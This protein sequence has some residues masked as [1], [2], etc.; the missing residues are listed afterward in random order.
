MDHDH[1]GV[2]AVVDPDLAG[3]ERRRGRVAKLAHPLGVSGPAGPGVTAR[4]AAGP[5]APSRGP[6]LG[7]RAA[8]LGAGTL[9]TGSGGVDAAPRSQVNAS[10]GEDR[11]GV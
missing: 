4:P 5:I 11:V 9:A 3:D 8:T 6:G 10:C 2:G 1:V 7:A